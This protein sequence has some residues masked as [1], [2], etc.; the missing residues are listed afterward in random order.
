M[1]TH[2][3]V[4]DRTIFT[5]C[6]HPSSNA[7]YDGVWNVISCEF[8][9][10]LEPGV[11]QSS[12]LWTLERQRRVGIKA[13]IILRFQKDRPSRGEHVELVNSGNGLGH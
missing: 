13:V 1:K 2:R 4:F 6:N 7:I 12:T 8:H 11:S 10:L 3:C 9:V 5:Q